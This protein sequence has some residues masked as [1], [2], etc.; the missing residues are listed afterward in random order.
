M[1]RLIVSEFLTLDGVMQSPGYPD[2]D[3][4][5]G[6]QHGGWNQ[7]YFDE[8]FGNAIL[9]T[10]AATD[11]L[12]RGRRTYEIFAAHWPNQPPDDPIASRFNELA[13][14]V[15]STTLQEPLGWMNTTLAG[16]DGAAAVRRLKDTAGSSILVLGSGELVQ[17][18]AR[19]GLIDEYR[20]A[21]H[22]LVLG[23][24]SRLF[25]EPGPVRLSLVGSETTTTGV[26]MLTYQVLSAAA[27]SA[28]ATV[29]ERA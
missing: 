12:L 7:P 22:P 24:G 15:V 4:S 17:T 5:G 18:L 29:D 14:V 1:R 11:V 13:K 10:L 20:L 2:E 25:R 8:K 21:I 23:S 3:R 16:T 26:L 9:A 6:F 28:T 27:R 19:E